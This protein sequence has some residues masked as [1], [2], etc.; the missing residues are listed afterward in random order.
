[1]VVKCRLGNTRTRVDS[2]GVWH[3]TGAER[4]QVQDT[5]SIS[6]PGRQKVAVWE[7]CGSAAVP[8]CFVWI[9][10]VSYA[11][12]IL[13]LGFLCLFL[14]YSLIIMECENLA[15]FSSYQN[16]FRLCDQFLS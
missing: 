7:W 1:M 2:T 8:A 13:E 11:V 9:T 16:K 5:G 12:V 15:L 4:V 10:A 6:P 3:R 14:V